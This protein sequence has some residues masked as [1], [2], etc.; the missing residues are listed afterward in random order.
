VAL[1]IIF[2]DKFIETRKYTYHATE[3]RK[4]NRLIL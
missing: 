3:R 1:N 2:T 4:E